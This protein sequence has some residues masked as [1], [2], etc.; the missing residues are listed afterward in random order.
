MRV[1]KILLGDFWLIPYKIIQTNIT[2]TTCQTIRKITY[3]IVGVTDL[4]GELSVAF[5]SMTKVPL[6]RI[7]TSYRAS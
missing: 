3:E 7:T 4:G 1:K 2:R 5:S 6:Y